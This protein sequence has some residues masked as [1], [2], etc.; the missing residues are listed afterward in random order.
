M[1][2][3]ASQTLIS[4]SDRSTNNRNAVIIRVQYSLVAR[5]TRAVRLI[6]MHKQYG[7]DLLSGQFYVSLVSPRNPC[8]AFLQM[9]RYKETEYGAWALSANESAP[10]FCLMMHKQQVRSGEQVRGD[11][12][13]VGHGT[14]Q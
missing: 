6:A 4:Q 14:V 7:G 11:G 8:K 12:E 13:G 3:N 9:F 10:V 5:A 1:D 2:R